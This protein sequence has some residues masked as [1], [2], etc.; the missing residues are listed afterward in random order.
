M[1]NLA[2]TGELNSLLPASDRGRRYIGNL[3]ATE[4]TPVRVARLDEILD[5]VA[6]GAQSAFLKSDTQGYDF[7]VLQGAGWVLDRISAIHVE[8]MFQDLYT[9]ATD[10]LE[11]LT[12]LRGKGFD[13]VDLVP[14]LRAGGLMAEADA[15][16]CRQGPDGAGS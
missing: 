2:G 10:Y 1:L 4:A 16:L 3:R 12:W 8:L 15:L 11:V 13:L 7:Q 6:P 9:G 5:D 14:R